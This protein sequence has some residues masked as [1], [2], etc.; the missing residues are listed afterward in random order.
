M[1]KSRY[2]YL[3]I[4]PELHLELLVR[5]MLPHRWLF[6]KPNTH[7]DLVVRA[8]R[9]DDHKRV[10][11]S[12]EGADAPVIRNAIPGS[13]FLVCGFLL[14]GIGVLNNMALL[15]RRTFR[16]KIPPMA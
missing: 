4:F 6:K 15:E 2:S 14:I 8:I 7:S 13:T 11:L 1:N 10:R 5:S 12:A 16:T 9:T 3:K